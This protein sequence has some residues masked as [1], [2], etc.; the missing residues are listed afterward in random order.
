MV[1][2][3]GGH[4]A[5][6]LGVVELT[7]ALHYVL[8]LP[9]GP[10]AVG[11]RPPVLRAQAAHRPAGAVRARCGRPA[12]SAASPR[13]PR[14]RTTCSPSATPG[15]AIATAVGLALG[16]Q[17]AGPRQPRSSPS[18]ATPASSTAWRSRAS[19]R[20]ACSSGSSWSCSTTTRWASTGRRGR[21]PSTWPASAT[22]HTYERAAKRGEAIIEHI[23]LVGKIDARDD[24]P[25]QGGVKATLSA[26]QIFEQLGFMYVGPVD[27]HDLRTLI[28]MLKRAAAGRPPGAAARPHGEGPRLRARR[29]RPVPLP[30]PR[31][32]SR[33]RTAR[34]S[35]AKRRQARPG[36]AAFADAADRAG[37][38]R[39]SA[40][41]P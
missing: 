21:W 3:T 7:I 31:R 40:S 35:P 20:P 19:T 33:S 15:T 11:R 1:S 39:T 22:S 36:R 26:G 32:R 9:H 23:P 25:P 30:Q 28:S 5:S 34:R 29:R 6:N 38:S 10:A 18:S 27:G 2:R 37:R 13:P 14:A 12:G 16:D 4:L 8:R 41:S 17:R 24:P